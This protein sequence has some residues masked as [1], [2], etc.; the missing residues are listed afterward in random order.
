MEGEVLDWK[1]G[2]LLYSARPFHGQVSPQCREALCSVDPCVLEI[3][4]RKGKQAH[5]IPTWDPGAHRFSRN[6]QQGVGFPPCV[7]EG[8]A[9][10]EL[11]MV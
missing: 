5:C 9:P 10:N 6:G 4:K 2:A 11:L 7:W 3:P 1:Q 8:V